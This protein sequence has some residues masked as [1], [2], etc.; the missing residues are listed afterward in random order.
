MVAKLNWDIAGEQAESMEFE[1][2]KHSGLMFRILLFAAI[3]ILLL[4]CSDRPENVWN[5]PVDPDNSATGGDPYLVTA[6]IADGG[7]LLEWANAF[8]LNVAGFNVYRQDNGG[9]FVLYAALSGAESTFTD[10]AIENGHR[11][12]YYVVAKDASGNEANTTN[13]ASISVDTD[14]VVIINGNETTTGSRHVELTIIAYQA[15]R[16]RISNTPQV[17]DL[18][19]M[20]YSS[21]IEWNLATGA[22]DVKH[23]YVQVDYDESGHPTSDVASDSILPRFPSNLGFQILNTGSRINN[24]DSTTRNYITLDLNAF[25][26]DSVQVAQNP[27]F[28]G[29]VWLPYAEQVA[30]DLAG[31][32]VNGILDDQQRE[33]K[34]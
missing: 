20:A 17:E 28:A 4:S 32:P 11:Y 29:G 18:D 25:D 22:E 8:G 31:R 2:R 26:A 10:L 19:W 13:V 30:W 34:F 16:M 9:G 7:I 15:D 33:E 27:E 12:D 23:V 6:S 1:M 5:N 14:P 21:S 3:L 24:P